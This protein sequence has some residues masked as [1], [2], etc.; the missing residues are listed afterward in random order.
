M[1]ESHSE[2]LR[3]GMPVVPLGGNILYPQC[4]RFIIVESTAPT[5]IKT[6]TKPGTDIS[7][8]SKG[9]KEIQSIFHLHIPVGD[10][11]IFSTKSVIRKE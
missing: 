2:I 9:I 1:R 7:S 3:V 4:I 8:N 10:G 6:K 11:V 5:S